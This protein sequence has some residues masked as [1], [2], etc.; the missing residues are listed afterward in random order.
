MTIKVTYKDGSQGVFGPITGLSEADRV[1]GLLAV[2]AA[3]P[4]VKSATA[5]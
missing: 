1:A 2:L 3:R 5:E 4:D